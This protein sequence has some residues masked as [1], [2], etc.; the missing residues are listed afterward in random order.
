MRHPIS[1]ISLTF[2]AAFPLLAQR[3]IV[4]DAAERFQILDGFGACIWSTDVFP[5]YRFPEFYD[6]MVFDLGADILRIP[7]TPEE[8]PTEEELTYVL[9]LAQQFRARDIGKVMATPWSPPGRLKTNR[10]PILGGR[11]RPDRREDFARFLANYIETVDRLFNVR[12]DVVSLQNELLFVE[13][14]GSC[15]Y[16]P[17]QLREALRVVDRH[18]RENNISTEILLPEDM[19]FADR[20]PLYIEPLM[21]DPETR[22]FHG[23]FGSHG[24]NGWENWRKM[25]ASLEPYGR[26]F[27]M[28][29]TSGHQP[30]WQGGLSLAQ[31]L[32]DT[33][34]GGNASA[35]I[36]WQY[37]GRSATRF[38]L[39]GTEPEHTPKS[40][41]AKHFIRFARPGSIRIDAGGDTG[42]LRVSAFLAP[43]SG[44]ISVVIIN[45]GEEAVSSRIAVNH[46][47]SPRNWLAFTSREDS[48]MVNSSVKRGAAVSIPAKGI[49]SLYGVAGARS[50]TLPALRPAT[51]QAP[52]LGKSLVPAD[53]EAV[54]DRIHAAARANDVAR[55]EA[56]LAQGLD[57]NALNVSQLSPLHRAAWPG[58]VEVVGPL[59]K[60]GAD[61][62]RR[63]GTGGIALHIA[64]SRGHDAFIREVVARGGEVDLADDAGMTPLHRAAQGGQLGT[65]GI[66]LELAA[67]PNRTDEHGWTALHWAAAAP[68]HS[69]TGILRLLIDA[70][71]DPD[72]MDAEG[73]TPLHV[74]AMN[75][76]NPWSPRSGRLPYVNAQ[77]LRVLV[78]AGSEVDARDQNGRTALHWAGWMGETCF[79]EDVAKRPYFDYAVEAVRFLLAAGADPAAKDNDGKT[80]RDYAL[81]E[82]YTGIATLIDALPAHPWLAAR[83]TTTEASLPAIAMAATGAGDAEAAAA[84]VRQLRQAAAEGR[85]G[86]IRQLVAAGADLNDLTGQGGTPLHDAV[87]G[88]HMDSVR[89]LLQL[90]ADPGIRDSDGYTPLDRANQNGQ[91]AIAELLKP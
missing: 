27:W 14:Y 21:A 48:Y 91:D 85:N 52:P 13:P 76:V 8:H 18:F 46:L 59:V 54:D 20:F 72:A 23:L 12:I 22:D 58:H 77:R 90:G 40:Q 10:S 38:S 63:D 30:D 49:V 84:M 66:L 45:P 1:L 34:A 42:D 3:S 78:E 16:N 61:P 68:S 73:M 5:A 28:T 36:Y 50:Q 70:G 2:L 67:D 75:P 11:L 86:R 79:Y 35:Y 24:G 83:P 15:V 32:H 81:S 74:A 44:E 25:A 57:P 88:D 33:I 19:G 9:E 56:L 53:D 43:E 17:L 41:A 26:R 69:S 65:V 39:V 60:G 7:I 64:A 71:A 6:L 47:E 82:G 37:A 62:N 4:V 31:N 55:V 87:I 51:W 29:E 89:L 80:T